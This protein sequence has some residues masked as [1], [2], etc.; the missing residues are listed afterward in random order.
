MPLSFAPVS[1]ACSAAYTR[2]ARLSFGPIMV[3]IRPDHCGGVVEVTSHPAGQ[4]GRFMRAGMLA[5]PSIRG[6]NGRPAIPPA[7]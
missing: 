5:G 6:I 7:E 2:H 4:P 3:V 1:M